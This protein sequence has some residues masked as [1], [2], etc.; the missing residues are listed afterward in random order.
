MDI[1]SI[2]SCIPKF[3]ESLLLGKEISI[4]GIPVWLAGVF[5]KE[6][7]LFLYLFAEAEDDS[8][9]QELRRKA[10]KK[11]MRGTL[12]KREE[13]LLELEGQEDSI[14]DLVRG[15]R[16]KG[17]EYEFSSGTG[18]RLEEYSWEGRMLL[19]YLL[20]QGL[21]FGFLEERR[22]PS[23]QYV[24]FTLE[25]EYDSIPF[26]RKDLGRMEI[27]EAPR[28]HRVPVKRKIKLSIGPQPAR[29]QRFFCEP[30]QRDVEY[31]INQILLVDGW[32]ELKEKYDKMQKEG[33]FSSR[34]EYEMFISHLR[35]ICP[36]G[37]R[38]VAV[39]Y[40]CEE[41]TLEFYA[42]EQL[43]EKVKIQDGAVAFF[44]LAGG[45]SQKEGIHGQKLR[46]CMVQYPVAPAARE[47]ELELLRAFVQGHGN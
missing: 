31:C 32:S 9:Q 41:A 40:E 28:W 43:K 27:M 45:S 25:G 17:K 6:R 5:R 46:S 21:A 4:S 24:E 26:T 18:S 7:S 39:E 12:T 20:E 47:I 44:L 19:Y 29:M 1:K 11:R 15:I 2:R 30:L 34:E 33:L 16:V 13:L 23:V 42:K 36:P 37:M 14:L 3:D 10:D 38:N 8:R 35:Q 22:L